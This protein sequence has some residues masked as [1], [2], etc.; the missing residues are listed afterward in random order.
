[1]GYFNSI[2]NLPSKQVLIEKRSRDVILENLAMMG[3]LMALTIFVAMERIDSAELC[4]LKL[5]DASTE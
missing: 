3:F 2:H 1:M 5:D 4:R